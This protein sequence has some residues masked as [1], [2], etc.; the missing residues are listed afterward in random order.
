MQAMQGCPFCLRPQQ[1]SPPGRTPD[2]DQSA[3]KRER[4]RLQQL[5]VH[6]AAHGQGGH[7]AGVKEL[8]FVVLT[9]QS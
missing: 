8:G 5:V 4:G 1:K 2:G 3:R 9:A 7:I 6:G